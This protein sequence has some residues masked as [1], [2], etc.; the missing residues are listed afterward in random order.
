ML[1]AAGV[2]KAPY[3]PDWPPVLPTVLLP[4]IH[5]HSIRGGIELPK[6]VEIAAI[7]DCIGAIAPKEPEIAAVVGPTAGVI[8]ASGNVSGSRCTQRAVHSGLGAVAA[9]GAASAHP[10][11]F[12][13]CRI[14]LPKVVE[15]AAISTGIVA[16]PSKE[17]EIAAAVGP[18]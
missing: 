15:V 17:P 5:A 7:A 8:A 6:V 3:T 18:A 11:P 1:P 2:P 13:C 16:I 12:V 4:P 14:E 9:D 10:C